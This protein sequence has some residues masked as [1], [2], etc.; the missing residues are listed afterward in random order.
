M[1]EGDGETGHES[2]GEVGDLKLL[3]QKIHRRKGNPYSEE[4]EHTIVVWILVRER[5]QSRNWSVGR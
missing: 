1:A 3:D 5:L 2:N 4:E